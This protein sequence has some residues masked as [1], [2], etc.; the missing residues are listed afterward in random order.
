M[1]LALFP[2]HQI[3]HVLV[4]VP[5]PRKCDQESEEIPDDLNQDI[6]VAEKQTLRGDEDDGLLG[7]R[8]W[9][10]RRKAQQPQFQSHIPV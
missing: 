4:F 8:M 7:K 9:L 1:N 2:S 5:H 10:P 3:E 6:A